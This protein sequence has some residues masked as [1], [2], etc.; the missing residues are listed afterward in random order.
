[1][2]K[3][4]FLALIGLSTLAFNAQAQFLG[5]SIGPHGF[6]LGLGAPL[7]YAPAPVVYSAPVCY[8]QPTYYAAPPV[9]YAPAPVVYAAPP[10]C[11]PGYYGYRPTVVI[12]G[13]YRAW[14]GNYRG[15]GGHGGGWRR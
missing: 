1:M 6:S 11:Y 2:K 5:I 7:C 3:L 12:G 8:A 15:Y 14:H 10:I 4:T 13:G 9:C